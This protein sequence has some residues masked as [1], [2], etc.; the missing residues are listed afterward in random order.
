M[1]AANIV[2][3]HFLENTDF[4][5]FVLHIKNRRMMPFRFSTKT[6]VCNTLFIDCAENGI[7]R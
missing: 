2:G 1:F 4:G 6:E 3:N 5:Y 7:N